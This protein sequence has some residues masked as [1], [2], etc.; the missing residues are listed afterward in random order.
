MEILKAN[1]VSFF[2]RSNSELT[3]W[4]R[5]LN[6]GDALAISENQRAGIFARANQIGIKVKTRKIED[7]RVVV[8]R[9][10]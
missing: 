9:V 1:E 4:M 2:K 5:K 3:T 10:S 6:L 7:G 8:I